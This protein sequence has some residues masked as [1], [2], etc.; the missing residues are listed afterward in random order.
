MV[1]LYNVNVR[2]INDHLKKVFTYQELQKEA[3]ILKFRI[4]ASDVKNYNTQKGASM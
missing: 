4:T 2:T 3:V 1:T